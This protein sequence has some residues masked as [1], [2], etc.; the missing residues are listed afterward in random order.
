M[1]LLEEFLTRSFQAATM[2]ENIVTVLLFWE[3]VGWS[4]S[5]EVT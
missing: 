3:L 4:P 5:G 1:I 2:Q